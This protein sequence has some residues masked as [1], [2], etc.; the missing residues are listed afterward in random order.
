[1]IPII[2]PPTS[3]ILYACV[4]T[5][6]TSIATSTAVKLLGTYIIFRAFKSNTTSQYAEEWGI[7][8]AKERIA[9]NTYNIVE[10]KLGK[11]TAD[12]SSH[13]VNKFPEALEEAIVLDGVVL[14]ALGTPV[15]PAVIGATIA[16]DIRKAANEYFGKDAV[17]KNVGAAAVAGAIKY[18]IKSLTLDKK[19]LFIGAVNNGLYEYF[20][21]EVGDTVVNLDVIGLEA[22]LFQIEGMDVMLKIILK[23]NINFQSELLTTL[24]VTF[25]LSALSWVFLQDKK[26]HA[27]ITLERVPNHSKKVYNDIL[28]LAQKCHEYVYDCASKMLSKEVTQNELITSRENNTNAEQMCYINPFK[29]LDVCYIDEFEEQNKLATSS[30]NELEA[31]KYDL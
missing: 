10:S 12:V 27:I 9:N 3:T 8:E 26:E 19:T 22:S 7:Y 28:V 2:I 30:E 23:E 6:A 1:M 20:K 4:T 13:L 11:A 15:L 21:P 17:V 16:Y 29:D 24:K 31:V 14:C 25:R 18:G 5:A